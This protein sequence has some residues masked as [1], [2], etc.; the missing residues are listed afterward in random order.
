MDLHGSKAYVHVD[1]GSTLET[2]RIG[3]LFESMAHF[4]TIL[5]ELQ[6]R[7]QLNFLCQESDPHYMVIVCP[8]VYRPHSFIK[9]SSDILHVSSNYF[10]STDVAG[11]PQYTNRPP[12]LPEAPLPVAHTA[13][14][15]HSH[16]DLADQALAHEHDLQHHHDLHQSAHAMGF[17]ASA[18]TASAD[19]D[20]AGASLVTMPFFHH[21]TLSLSI[22]SSSGQPKSELEQPGS[23]GQPERCPF[24]ICARTRKGGQVVITE[25]Y[26]EHNEDCP[27]RKFT[28]ATVK[29]LHRVVKPYLQS[30]REPL[31]ARQLI[32]YIK[33][34][35]D[36]DVRYTAAVR[37]LNLEYS[38]AGLSHLKV[39][40]NSFQQLPS[41]LQLFENTNP[42]SVTDYELLQDGTFRR[43]FLCPRA[44]QLAFP[45]C[46]PII[47][48]MK[49]P[50][51]SSFG[52]FVFAAFSSDGQSNFLP[53][54][55]SLVSSYQVDDWLYFLTL[56]RKSIVQLNEPD[57]C[58]I[59]VMTSGE[60][61]VSTARQQILPGTIE[62][63]CVNEI[64]KHIIATFR[65]SASL[66]RA[67][68]AAAKAPSKA[69]LDTALEVIKGMRPDV[70]GYLTSLDVA[71]WTCMCPRP[72]FGQLTLPFPADVLTP[73]LGKSPANRGAY[74]D[75]LLDWTQ[76]VSSM[77]YPQMVKYDAMLKQGL[78][79]PTEY[80]ERLDSLMQE[81]KQFQV[82]QIS[83]TE[84]YVVDST[85]GMSRRLIDIQHM[86]CSCGEFHRSLFPCV[87][88]VA[89]VLYDVS[90]S[91]I[92]REVV[93]YL[94]V[95]FKVDS[96]FA[97]YSQRFVPIDPSMLEH[98]EGIL[99]PKIFKPVPSRRKASTAEHAS[100]ELDDI[101]VAGTT[102]SSAPPGHP[103][104]LDFGLLQPASQLSSLGSPSNSHLSQLY[105]PDKET[106]FGAPSDVSVP[107]TLLPPTPSSTPQLAD[108]T[109]KTRKVVCPM[110]GWNHYKKTGCRGQSKDL[111]AQ[112]LGQDLPASL[113]EDSMHHEELPSSLNASLP[114]DSDSHLALH[115]AHL[116]HPHGS[117]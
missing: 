31:T 79:F 4:R 39:A 44:L 16:S 2:L 18:T 41:F 104:M 113:A 50:L 1:P 20:A 115:H 92:P 105:Q 27:A 47:H 84:F 107:Q 106:L 117:S 69:A 54:A 38:G 53:L 111:R 29:G 40:R 28:H 87:H 37:V 17:S 65:P 61:E 80:R 85:N 43:L 30:L 62:I 36:L 59:L 81:A 48:L 56:L 12:T 83:P 21:P 51:S 25:A 94:H 110:C 64:I 24:R 15:S 91:L 34:T 52:G 86:A 74:L 73:F 26:V 57:S 90:R 103:V 77:Y 45:Y 13:D 72:K 5:R 100:S 66:L 108:G 14:G 78:V 95:S 101:N 93:D 22:L 67:C 58:N 8:V 42:G 114:L 76:A 112:V 99:A 71:K 68:G 109:P 32:N 3:Q 23:Q 46:Q 9:R 75:L 55:I 102:A 98:T 11:P 35:Y 88:T 19:L 7:F 97:I 33:L 63:I 70:Y 89:A 96:L 49:H 82:N 60:T 6:V 116:L 10:Q